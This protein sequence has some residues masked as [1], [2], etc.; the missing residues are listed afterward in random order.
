LRP[1]TVE[2]GDATDEREAEPEAA[3][4]AVGSALALHEEIEDTGKHRGIDA[5]AGVAN[6]QHGLAVDGAQRDLDRAFRRGELERVAHE[7][8]DD[9][10]EPC[11]VDVGPHRIE[12]EA[13]RVSLRA[14]A[15]GERGHGVPDRLRELDRAPLEDDLA[16]CHPGDV[17][18]VVDQ[19]GELSVLSR[20]DLAG[21]RGGVRRRILGV[22]HA[23]RVR[24]G[25]ERVAQLVAQH[26]EEWSLP[27]LAAS[28]SAR[29]ACSRASK[30]A[31]WTAAAAWWAS[32]TSAA[33][34]DTVNGRR[35]QLFA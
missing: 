3:R 19:M 6:A 2:L 29:A 31:F 18:E 24:D 26:G 13:D 17:E 15:L 28:A 14:A 33:S 12:I 10:L 7:V 34:S 21:T 11:L 23:H 25:G 22:E 5:H 32:V 35:V 4:T 20:D 9:L 27:R 16:E 1:S 8:D 30:R